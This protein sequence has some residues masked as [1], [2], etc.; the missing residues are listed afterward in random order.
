MFH[1]HY[2]TV[3]LENKERILF[4]YLLMFVHV[5]FYIIKVVKKFI[6]IIIY[7]YLFN[8]FFF[9]SKKKLIYIKKLLIEKFFFYIKE[10]NKDKNKKDK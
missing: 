4:L 5:L 1:I 2:I 9:F 6:Y 3:D 8:F 7:V 10:L